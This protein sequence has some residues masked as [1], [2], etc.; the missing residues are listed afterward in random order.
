VA[1]YA[2]ELSINEMKPG[3]WLVCPCPY[4]TTT[5]GSKILYN[6]FVDMEPWPNNHKQ[7]CTE[8]TQESN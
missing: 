5:D 7:Y 8:C 2:N 1:Y 3:D 6:N 4:L